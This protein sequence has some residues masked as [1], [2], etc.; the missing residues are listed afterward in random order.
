MNISI[1][2]SLQAY[3]ILEDYL[4]LRNPACRAHANASHFI[5]S[6]TLHGCNTQV[7]HHK[8]QTAFTNAVRAAADSQTY[9]V[10]NHAYNCSEMVD[11]A[12]GK[13]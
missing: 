7:V 5:L 6:S 3:G 10:L 11:Q 1:F 8:A 12:T 4:S 2:L 13:C 9:P